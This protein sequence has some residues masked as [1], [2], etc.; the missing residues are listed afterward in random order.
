MYYILE[1]L[2][3]YVL[4]HS[5]LKLIVHILAERSSDGCAERWQDSSLLALQQL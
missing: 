4:Q 5:V 1:A 3:T 2:E